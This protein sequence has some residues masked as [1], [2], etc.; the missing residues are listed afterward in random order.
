MPMNS[1]TLLPERSEQN[2]SSI[3]IYTGALTPQCLVKNV[4]VIKKAFPALPLGFYD[5]LIDM[6]QEDK[7]SDERLSDAVNHVIK[8]C[9]YPTPT[10]AQFLSWDR[11]IQVL[12][13]DGMMKKITEFGGDEMA[14]KIFANQYSAIQFPDREKPVW[15]HVND[16]KMYNLKPIQ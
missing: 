12:N 5:V 10:I 14:G 6:V 15:V 11:R 9:I 2:S 16:V 7:F 13:F 8:N 4:A 1:L 3:S